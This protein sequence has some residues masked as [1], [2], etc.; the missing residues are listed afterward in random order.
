MNANNDSDLTF[1]TVDDVA[2]TPTL[3]HGPGAQFQGLRN[4]TTAFSEDV[5]VAFTLQASTATVNGTTVLACSDDPTRRW[6][7][8]SGGGGGGTVGPTEVAYGDALGNLTSSPNMVFDDVNDT[9]T[10]TGNG[11][12]DSPAM[13]IDSPL[14]GGSAFSN[15]QQD[16]KSVGTLV[17]SRRVLV[18]PAIPATAVLEQMRS[19][20]ALDSFQF[21]DVNGHPCILALP[22]ARDA[23]IGSLDVLATNATKGFAFDP[24]TAGVPSGIPANLASFINMVPHV[25]DT[26]NHR[27]Y[28]YVG[29]T[30]H[31]AALDDGGVAVGWENQEFAWTQTL[32]A[33]FNTLS[34]VISTDFNDGKAVGIATLN[35]LLT[36]YANG[37]YQIG[38]GGAS[39]VNLGS[40]V[41]QIVVA[42]PKVDVWAAS[43]KYRYTGSSFTNA[44][45]QY[46]LFLFDLAG[47]GTGLWADQSV[48]G[49][50]FQLR[51]FYAGGVS[52][53]DFSCGAVGTLG[54][55]D[56]PVGA[57]FRPRMAFDG[58][59][60]KV[61]FGT[62]LALT[63]TGAQLTHMV[64]SPSYLYLG[65]NDATI[66]AACDGMFAATI[67]N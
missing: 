11:V 31:Y 6:K 53:E 24:T 1:E 2:A 10:F 44:K 63:L 54:S 23:G 29:G 27:I 4:G 18:T 25:V 51:H 59:S 66:V 38:S 56:A 60:L 12:F 50:V 42:A 28:Y 41:N 47:N 14:D 48:S 3:S 62:T 40:V 46:V 55:A 39:N 58:T 61:Y 20:N 49:T 15:A 26:T 67:A 43:T 52:H 5:G 13:E 65:G 33:P 45:L 16:W 8:S 21:T 36:T 34:S 35:T 19:S 30:W 17:E 64:S 57:F 7:V 37:V 22:T 32:G 9:A